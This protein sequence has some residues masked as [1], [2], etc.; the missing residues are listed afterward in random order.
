MKSAL[1]TAGGFFIG[2][3]LIGTALR[4]APGPSGWFL[5]FILAIAAF[6]V[7]VAIHYNPPPK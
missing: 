5:L 4:D 6:G 1:C 3:G 2:A 7:A